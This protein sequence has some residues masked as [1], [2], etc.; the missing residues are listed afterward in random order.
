MQFIYSKFRNEYDATIGVEFGSKQINLPNNTVI[1]A[2]IWDT[3][4]VFL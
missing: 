3:V 4:S 2:Q 1:K